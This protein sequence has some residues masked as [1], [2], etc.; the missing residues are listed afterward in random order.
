MACTA[1]YGLEDGALAP[2]MTA[3]TFDG[4]R[5][6]VRFR[7]VGAGLRCPDG[8]LRGFTLCGENGVHLEAGARIVSPDT[9]EV[10]HPAACRAAGFTYA[11]ALYNQRANLYG[12]RRRARRPLPPGYGAACVYRAPRMAGRGQGGRL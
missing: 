4:G 8:T 10:T 9:V 7:D 12:Q 11:F 5:T 1:V 6:L 2:R 3:V